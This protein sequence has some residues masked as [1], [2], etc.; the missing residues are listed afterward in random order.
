MAQILGRLEPLGPHEVGA[1]AQAPIMFYN[2]VTMVG[3][4][5]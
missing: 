1:T 4:F 3:V 5:I 2:V